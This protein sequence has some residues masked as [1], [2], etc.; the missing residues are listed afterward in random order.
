MFIAQLD[1]VDTYDVHGRR[2]NDINTLSEYIHDILLEHT[3]KSRPDED[4][5]T[6]RFC[7]VTPFTLYDFNLYRSKAHEE[8][9]PAESKKEY[10]I[11]NESK[12]LSPV[13]DILYPPP[14][15]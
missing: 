7:Q 6:A 8:V 10:A 13:M 14:K 9:L 4:N 12:L 5:D 1:E 11:F 15:S 2:Q 3:R